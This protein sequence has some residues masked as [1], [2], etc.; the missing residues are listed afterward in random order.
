[1]A[2][3]LIIDDAGTSRNGNV[4]S[5]SSLVASGNDL[6]VAY[7]CDED[8]SPATTNDLRFAWRPAGT[9]QWTTVDNGPAGGGPLARASDG[10]YHV[11]YGNDGLRWAYGSGNAWTLVPGKVDPTG[12]TFLC[13]ALDSADRP[14]VTFLEPATANQWSI[15][16]TRWNGTEW[17][18]MPANLLV[19][20][21]NT[22]PK[23]YMALDSLDRPHV[24]YAVT[25]GG[26]RHA[27]FRNNGWYVDHIGGTETTT[28]VTLA[29][30]D[31]DGLHVA[32]CTYETGLIYAH[33][34]PG[35]TWNLETVLTG[36]PYVA[37]SIAIAVDAQRRPAISFV[38]K[39]TRDLC[40]AA[41]P[42]TGWTVTRLDGDGLSD[43]AF[44]LGTFC[45]SIAFDADGYAH[46]TYEAVTHYDGG[47]RRR[48]DLRIASIRPY[49]RSDFNGDL[50]TDFFDYL[51]FVAALDAE[52]PSAD[53]NG[54]NVVDFF[55]YLDYVAAFDAGCD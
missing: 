32:F 36:D 23:N 35:G 22:L 6:A 44:V 28:G 14:H 26:A 1:M 29:I 24:A 40:L 2:Q 17:E 55:D 7:S 11:I 50:L 49:C 51:D 18:R 45:T 25:S 19:S 4:G 46:V 37:S 41:R 31:V 15:R 43:G 33:K 42:G 9:W 34:A 38:T 48:S 20:T 27:Y 54:D 47:A 12:G 3:T 5:Y 8:F 52:D 13:M 10:V 30:D 39:N 21:S 16:Y 53:F